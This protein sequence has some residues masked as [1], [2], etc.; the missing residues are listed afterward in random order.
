VPRL[1]GADPGG[2]SVLKRPARW[3]THG[4]DVL[5]RPYEPRDRKAV[6]TICCDTADCGEAVENFFE[7]REFIADL[8]TRYY[9]DF[10]PQS[11]WVA[12]TDGVVIG[13]LNGCLD[14][15]RFNRAQ[16]WIAVWAGLRAMVRGVIFRRDVWRWLP[17]LWRTWRSG[18]RSAGWPAKEYPAHLHVNVNKE[19]RGSLIGPRLVEEFFKQARAAG[20]RGVHVSVRGDNEGGC[21]FFERLG[22][23]QLARSPMIVA[24]RDG[25]LHTHRVIYGKKL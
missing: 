3:P 22:F 13:Y 12:E 18:G 6:R 10:E 21:R 19:A 9:T 16:L 20:V 15:R 4:I 24:K 1:R 8:V 14:P 23:A 2:P 25:W 7:D 17:A 11:S 5:I